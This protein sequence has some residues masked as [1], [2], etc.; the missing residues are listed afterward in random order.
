MLV[1]NRTKNEYALIN[2]LDLLC[3]PKKIMNRSI[4]RN[5]QTMKGKWVV[6][7]N[8]GVKFKTLGEVFNYLE[9]FLKNDLENN[10][11]SLSCYGEYPPEEIPTISGEYTRNAYCW[12]RLV[13][14][15]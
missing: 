13:I 15:P 1:H 14:P 2:P 10:L 5:V 9:D 8:R 4:N 6:D 12:I 11:R 7:F 3:I